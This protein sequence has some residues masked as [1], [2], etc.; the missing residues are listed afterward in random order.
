M[1]ATFDEDLMSELV[2]VC[3]SRVWNTSLTSF[4]NRVPEAITVPSL[5]SWCEAALT[6]I[7]ALLATPCFRSTEMNLLTCNDQSELS[8][9]IT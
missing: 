9:V 5:S 3:R 7:L 4:W 8:I 1:S 2:C 6:M